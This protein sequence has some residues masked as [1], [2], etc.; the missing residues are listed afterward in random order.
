MCYKLKLITDQYYIRLICSPLNFIEENFRF[1]MDTFKVQGTD[2]DEYMVHMFS[3][4]T[5]N[6]IPTN[7]DDSTI[8]NSSSATSEVTQPRILSTG[9]EL[10]GHTWI[11]K[12]NFNMVT[13]H[14][15]SYQ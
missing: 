10:R 15:E 7:S 13:L 6:F 14:G 11:S 12:S 9:S 4:W 2:S 8:Q 1:F 5:W 3:H